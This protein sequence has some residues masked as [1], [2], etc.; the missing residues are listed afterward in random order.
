MELV[1]ATTLW[2]RLTGLLRRGCCA[3][4]EVLMLIPCKSIHT[5]GMRSPIDV[6]FLNDTGEVVAS[7]RGLAPAK[8]RSHP[9]AEAVLERRSC[10]D[11]YWPSKGEVLIASLVH[12]C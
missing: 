7:E 10:A 4:G 9:E 5:F 2:S 8:I 12:T 6:A 11:S 3:H 1:L